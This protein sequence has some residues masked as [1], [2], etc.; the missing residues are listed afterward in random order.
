V[1]DVARRAAILA[2]AT[3]VAV[4]AEGIRRAVYLDPP[5]IATVCF[6]H[7]GPDVRVGQPLRSMDECKALLNADMLKAV[8]IVE[9]CQPG[10]PVPITAML[11]DGVLNGGPTMA[12]D[13]KNS[14]MARMLDAKDY[15]G[16]C[17]QHPRWN[18][19]RVLGV[20]IELPGLTKR[21]LLREQIC[22]TYRNL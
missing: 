9:R 18:K 2:L 14:T 5:G 15:E 3:T 17:H 6:G 19:A 16:A 12:C 20:L 11:A 7:T 22:L 21:T 1:N 4:P 10:L 13:R 8:D